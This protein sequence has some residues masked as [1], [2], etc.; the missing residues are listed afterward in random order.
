MTL[1]RP[2]SITVVKV[3]GSLFDW[4]GFPRRLSE[5]LDTRRTV[6]PSE[7][8]VLIAGGGAAVDTI[9]ALDNIHGLGDN[10]AHRLALHTM[11][12]TAV[13]L[14]TLVPGT[15][16]VNDFAAVKA[17][18]E[19]GSVP[20]LAPRSWLDRDGDCNEGLPATW[21][22]TSDSIAAWSAVRLGADRLVLLKS[23]PL[24]RG[25]NLQEAVRL[26]LVDPWLPLVARTLP[27]VEY[28]HLR[29]RV[30]TPQLLS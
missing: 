20:I 7:R 11:D 5:F 6:D 26:K 4:P 8:F 16:A 22:V 25:A 27:R 23:A 15:V 13:I 18:W 10:A 30:C 2:T 14:A 19:N 17:A 3:G 21:D 9:R 24:P 1:P 28:V 12:L 29:E